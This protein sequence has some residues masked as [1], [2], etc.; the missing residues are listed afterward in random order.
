MFAIVDIETTGG[1][2][3]RNRI[4]EI[5]IVIH[6]GEKIV[7]EWSTLINP[8]RNIPSTV[9]AIHGITDAMVSDAPRF[10]EVAKDIWQRLEEN[11]FVAHNVNFDY[12]FVKS[13][14]ESLGAKFSLKKLCTVRLARKIFPGHK[15]YSLGSICGDRKIPISDR[16]RALGDAKA[17]AILMDQ[18]IQADEDGWI[19][20]FLKRNSREATLPAHLP[21]EE[22]ENLPER[23]GVYYFLDGKGKIIYVG[24]AKNIKSRILGHFSGDNTSFN[25][26]N[27]KAQIHHISFEETGN[28]LVA[29]LLE[30]YEIRKHWP[31]F[32]RA[33]KH[34]NPNTGLYVYEDNKGYL[35]WVLSRTMKGQQPY[36]S[37]YN[38]SEGREK[39]SELVKRFNLCPKLSGLQTGQGTCFDYRIGKCQ[40]ACDEMESPG[41]YNKKVQ[42]ALSFL[43]SEED[44]LLIVGRGRSVEEKALVWVDKGKFRGFGYVK[45]E[46]TITQVEEVNQ[47]IR[48]L[49]DN[50]DFQKI[51]RSFLRKS[52]GYQVMKF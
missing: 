37:F 50:Q 3:E 18:I 42:E 40:G 8:E 5:A 1:Y 52:Q 33:Q 49:P 44:S 4:V 36:H 48:P 9:T 11:I 12:S 29:L 35:R 2:A 31:P 30:S 16:H 15:S 28:E 25:Q 26:S 27:F 43:K 19:E 6:D 45:E 10:F 17:T 32:N 21:K 14:F 22:F 46:F 38:L 47:Y 41:Y 20:K 7:E 24:K 39:V 23:P 34:V 13:E 51:I